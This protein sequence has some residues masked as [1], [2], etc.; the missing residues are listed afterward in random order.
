MELT[1]MMIGGVTPFGLPSDLPLYVDAPIEALD[2]IVV[3]GG[4][5]SQKLKVPP[6]AITALSNAEV[7]EGLGLPS[8]D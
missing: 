4:S 5:R 7:I 2:Y 3:G 6:A 8:R 1:R